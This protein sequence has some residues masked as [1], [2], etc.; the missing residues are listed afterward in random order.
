MREYSACAMF[1]SDHVCQGLNTVLF[2]SFDAS[3]FRV[4]R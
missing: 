3:I 2:S 4:C 1:A